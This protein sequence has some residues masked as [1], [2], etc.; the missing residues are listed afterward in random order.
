MTMH[1]RYTEPHAESSVLLTIDTQVDFTSPDGVATIDG[2]QAV[3]PAIAEVAAAHRRAGRPIVHMIRL[4]RRDGSNV[5]LCRRGVIELGGS[6]VAP[7]S[8]RSQIVPE[9]L[10]RPT[11]LDHE[12]LLAGELQP[13]SGDEYI[14]Y[15]P[16]WGAFYQ[17]A[18]HDRLVDWQVDTVALAGCNFPN[19][20]RTTLY[21]ASERDLRIVL[22]ADAVSGIY[23][24]GVE[25]LRRIGAHVTTASGWSERLA[26]ITR[27]PTPLVDRSA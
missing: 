2:T 20:P 18:L 23:D 19:C 14:M 6:I 12:L 27:R 24:R 25:E 15:K 7:A 10:G 1:D 13:V 17:T 11:E 22:I 8:P 9:I 21:E 4:Y 16:R 3:V 5:D 26:A